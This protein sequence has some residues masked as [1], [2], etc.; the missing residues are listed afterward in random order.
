MRILLTAL[1]A[2]LALAA[3]A[4]AARRHTPAGDAAARRLLLARAELGPGWTA[5]RSRPAVPA[6]TCATAGPAGAAEIGSA[7]TPTFRLGPAGPFLSE[8]AFAYR[9]AGDAAAVWRHLAG[10]AALG[11]LAQSVASGSTK[12]VSFSVRRR[13]ALALPAL[14]PRS[15]GYRVVALATLQ[16]QS[17]EAF[18][19]LVL[20][21]RGDRLVELSFSAFAKPLDRAAELALVRRALRRL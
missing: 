11:C 13:E 1:A 7:V 20:L 8:A 12:T 18:V 2:A 4:A 6:L 5:A 10:G 14:A 19:D 17:S 16:G 9:S 21:G 15:A 3:P